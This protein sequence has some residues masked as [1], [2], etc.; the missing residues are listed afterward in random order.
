MVPEEKAE[1]ERELL[2]PPLPVKACDMKLFIARATRF[3]TRNSGLSPVMLMLD[4]EGWY[5]R[6][7]SC[8]YEAELFSQEA[9]ICCSKLPSRTAVEYVLTQYDIAHS[10]AVASS[11]ESTGLDIRD[12]N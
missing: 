10:H 9:L 3:A 5:M 4:A 11:E 6:S 12:E 1:P 8:E 2:M 7:E